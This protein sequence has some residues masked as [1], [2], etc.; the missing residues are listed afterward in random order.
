[1]LE[2][3]FQ[4]DPIRSTG[5]YFPSPYI[6]K[7]TI[8]NDTVTADIIVFINNAVSGFVFTPSGVSE[9]D[10]AY[11]NRVLGTNIF[12]YI[13][14]LKDFSEEEYQSW[15]NQQKLFKNSLVQN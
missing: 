8:N 13:L 3:T 11:S 15:I 12:Y 1:M 14:W 2:L 4:G 5:E 6:N 10:D 9:A 7:V